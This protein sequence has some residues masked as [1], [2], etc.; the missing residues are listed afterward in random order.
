[1]KSKLLTV[2]TAERYVNFHLKHQMLFCYIPVDP[3]C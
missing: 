2:V 1:L 3:Y